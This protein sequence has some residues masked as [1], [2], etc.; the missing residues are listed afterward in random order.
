MISGEVS[1]DFRTAQALADLQA[2]AREAPPPIVA[3][4]AAGSPVAG[5]EGVL[6]K[7]ITEHGCRLDGP[8]GQSLYP[9]LKLAATLPE[10]GIDSFLLAT[11]ILLADRLQ[12]GGGGDDLFW[13]W[14]A[15]RTR[16]REA[17][18]PVR[19]AIYQGYLRLDELG[20][21]A[22]FDKPERD[23][24]CRHDAG[25]VIAD[26]TRS[27]DPDASAV[28][29][30]LAEAGSVGAATEVWERRGAR[31]VSEQAHAML[32]GIRHVFESSVEFAPAAKSENAIGPIIPFDTY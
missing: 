31:L 1:V 29:A 3:A 21:I 13:H 18:P 10:D 9:A 11:V 8:D 30:A 20:L 19:A 5:A 23:D 12:Q 24:L 28:L 7:L 14:D 25:D 26:L 27:N 17:E 15:F 2:A 22:L 6:T 4:L 32:S 16:Y